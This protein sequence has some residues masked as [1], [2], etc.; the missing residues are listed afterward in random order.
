MCV[1]RCSTG[2]GSNGGVAVTVVV[3]VEHNIQAD[4]TSKQLEIWVGPTQLQNAEEAL[5]GSFTSEVL[6]RE[7]TTTQ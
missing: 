1:L 4:E 3:M 6:V 5:D 7:T 2:P